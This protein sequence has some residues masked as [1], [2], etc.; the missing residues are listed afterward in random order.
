MK[1]LTFITMAAVF[2]CSSIDEGSVVAGSSRPMHVPI[3]R[4]RDGGTFDETEEDSGRLVRDCDRACKA[5][6][7]PPEV[8]PP[9][10][11][12]PRDRV[13]SREEMKRCI[14]DFPDVK[15]WPRGTIGE[16]ACCVDACLC[17][18]GN[19]LSGC[20]RAASP[21]CANARILPAESGAPR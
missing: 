21:K 3:R 8:P 1:L 13:L 7:P 17:D 15:T 12:I 10:P 4:L 6:Q 18:N 11:C 2:G 5:I 20:T 9:H 14:I 19:P 16:N